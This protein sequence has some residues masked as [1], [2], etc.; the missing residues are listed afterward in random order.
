MAAG[1]G[2]GSSLSRGTGTFWAVLDQRPRPDV[3]A[4]PYGP[5]WVLAWNVAV[6]ILDVTTVLS[7]A[8]P[9]ERRLSMPVLTRLSACDGKNR[10]VLRAQQEPKL[11]QGDFRNTAPGEIWR[12][13]R[14]PCQHV[15]PRP[16]FWATQRAVY[17]RNSACQ[18]NL[19]PILR[20]LSLPVLTSSAILI[21]ME[22]VVYIVLLIVLS[23]FAITFGSAFFRGAPFAP[24]NRKGA[25]T[26]IRLARIQAGD[27]AVD[28]GSGDGRLVIALARSGAEAHGLEINRLLVW[29]AN[30]A[31]KK[32]GLASRA[33]TLKKDLWKTDLS[34]YNV[35]TVFGISYIMDDL[36][37]KL[38]RELKPG[39]RVISNRFRF[40]NWKPV[41]SENGI[42]LYVKM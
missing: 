16:P 18:Q 27:R 41:E 9:T 19:S 23:V 13:S 2:H 4:E 28:I 33:R 24:T 17:A 30:R 11:C 32:A 31:I 35:V 12:A 29:W 15:P 39:S 22:L 1:R 5:V 3:V 25:E 38:D 14:L 26:M 6:T 21:R 8:R 40:P 34:S 42:H 10:R 37:K 7:R 36:E 20:L